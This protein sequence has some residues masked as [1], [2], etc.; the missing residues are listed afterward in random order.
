MALTA[1]P[2]SVGWDL[3]VQ[4]SG[5]YMTLHTACLTICIFF[6]EHHCGQRNKSGTLNSEW[7]WN[8]RGITGVRSC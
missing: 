1:L 8:I 7:N 6:L 2:S 5:E 3:R 4:R